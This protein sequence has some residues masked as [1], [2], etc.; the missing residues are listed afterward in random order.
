MEVTSNSGHSVLKMMRIPR[1]DPGIGL[2][3]L[4]QSHDNILI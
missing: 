3:L 1:E 2:W 4:P